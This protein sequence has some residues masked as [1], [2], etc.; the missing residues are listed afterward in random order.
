MAVTLKSYMETYKISNW[1]MQEVMENNKDF[2]SAYVNY[3]EGEDDFAHAMLSTKAINRL[4]EIF[5]VDGMPETD[6]KEEKTPAAEVKTKKTDS[7][8]KP[9]EKAPEEKKETK[10][11]AKPAAETKPKKKKKSKYGLSKAELQ[12]LFV[13]P[14]KVSKRFIRSFFLESDIFTLEEIAMAGDDDLFDDFKKRYCVLELKSGDWLIFEK[15][16]MDLISAY[17]IPDGASK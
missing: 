5:K 14:S 10:V 8:K 3:A 1:K 11:E 9:V 15:E 2:F 7:R 6:K 4:N 17:L 13:D 16:T 12:Q